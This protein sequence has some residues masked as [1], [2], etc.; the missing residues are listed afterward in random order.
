MA[1][2]TTTPV[3]SPIATVKSKLSD[4]TVEDGQLIFIQDRKEIA[5][6]F[7]GNRKVY[8][9]IEELATEAERTSLLAPV[10]GRYYYVTDPPVLWRYQEDGWVQITTPPE[11]L[12]NV[13]YMDTTDN[14]NTTFTE[15]ST[16][17]V[18]VDS[19]L[20]DSS[21]NP[22][23]NKV[24]TEEINS[25]RGHMPFFNKKLVAYGTSITARCDSIADNN[26]GYLAE[27]KKLCGF[28]DYVNHGASG[29]AFANNTK[30]GNG[31]NYK[32]RNTDFSEADLIT[33]EGCTNDFKLN[34][35]LGEIMP[36]GSTYNT[37]QFTGALQ[38]CIEHI[39][40]TDNSKPIVLVAD[41]QRDNDGYDCTFVNS[42]GCKLIDYVTRMGE[43][44]DLYGLP[45]CDWYHNGGLNSKNFSLF[46]IGDNLH[47]NLEGYKRLALTLAGTINNMSGRVVSANA[48]QTSAS[49]TLEIDGVTYDST[50]ASG[51][52]FRYVLTIDDKLYLYYSKNRLYLYKLDDDT[53]NE[54]VDPDSTLRAVATNNVFGD[55]VEFKS[56]NLMTPL[57]IPFYRMPNTRQFSQL[58]WSSH[59]LYNSTDGTT[60]FSGTQK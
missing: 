50:V 59:N 30:N 2:S 55:T 6:D 34:V 4:L 53:F 3:L 44:A 36:M 13:V 46:T 26:G 21:I 37:D 51:Y 8:K 20:S 54:V 39:L 1:E 16:S 11:N 15:T 35:E 41:P 33:I 60:L 24:I 49:E 12:E 58:V 31:I 38:D 23:Q 45:I 57:Y 27:L 28:S 48:D 7:G 32:V 29:W 42:A 5:F 43:L 18:T 14:E 10:T 47:P 9:Q 56:F 40:N 52:P 25:L 22:V 19:V 17:N